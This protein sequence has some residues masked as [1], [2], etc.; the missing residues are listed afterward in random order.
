ML[1]EAVSIKIDLVVQALDILLYG[2]DELRLILLDGT[3]NLHS[4]VE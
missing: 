2:I 4:D 1:A 3:T